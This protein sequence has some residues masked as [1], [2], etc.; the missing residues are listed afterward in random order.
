MVDALLSLRAGL[1]RSAAVLATVACVLAGGCA[2]TPQAVHREA[3]LKRL[4]DLL[5]GRY[6]NQEQIAADRRAGRTPHEPLALTVVSVD[7][8]Q[9]GEHV[10]YI[11]ETAGRI[12]TPGTPH[13][14]LAQHLASIQVVNGKIVAALWTFTDPGRW[15]EGASSPE[16]FSSLQPQDVKQMPGCQLSWTVGVDKITATDDARLC[17]ATSPLTDAVEPLRIRIELTRDELAVSA[18][19]VD[20]AQAGGEPAA[21]SYTRFRRS[22]GP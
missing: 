2:E 16:F 7:A 13:L 12:E 17:R 3:E 1:G 22:G 21:D 4:A 19:T 9:I 20:A 11:E 5:P 15:H 6:D 18:Q 8:L 14:I 10:F